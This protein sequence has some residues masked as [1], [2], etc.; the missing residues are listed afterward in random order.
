MLPIPST[1]GRTESQVDVMF[2]GGFGDYGHHQDRYIDFVG[3]TTDPL[4]LGFFG[5]LASGAA[6]SGI[7]V[8]VD[9]SVPEKKDDAQKT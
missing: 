2:D 7:A 1:D 5:S 9:V 8:A 4:V 6:V 3:S